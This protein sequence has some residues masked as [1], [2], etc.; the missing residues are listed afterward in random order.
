MC[1]EAG[2]IPLHAAK[3]TIGRAVHKEKSS[4]CFAAA[5]TGLENGNGFR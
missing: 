4:A 1:S 2:G 5:A 3:Q